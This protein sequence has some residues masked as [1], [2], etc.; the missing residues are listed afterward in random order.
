MT[1]GGRPI[2]LYVDRGFDHRPIA[3]ALA[4][5]LEAREAV[6]AAEAGDVVAIVT[7]AVPIGPADVAP[8]PRLQV[9]VTCTIGTD[10][11]DLEG[12][13]ARGIAVRN[14]PTYCTGEV[15]DHALAC[16]LAGW[17]GLV[18]LDAAVRD[19]RIRKGNLLVLEA[20]GGGFTWGAAAVRY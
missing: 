18:A 7:G 19:G 5:E 3:E 15:A 17:R 12:L 13:Q 8:Y 16:V 11:L 2:V 20:M 14:T 6:G 1:G 10:H 4:G 9:V